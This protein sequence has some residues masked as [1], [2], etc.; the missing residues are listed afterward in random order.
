MKN[1]SSLFNYLITPSQ[2]NKLVYLLNQMLENHLLTEELYLNLIK[3]LLLI[4]HLNKDCFDIYYNILH[5]ISFNIDIIKTLYSIDLSKQVDVIDT[6]IEDIIISTH[7]YIVS[8]YSFP[9]PNDKIIEWINIIHSI[10]KLDTSLNFKIS[11]Y[12]YIIKHSIDI[13][14]IINIINRLVHR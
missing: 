8:N 5:H 13:N 14:P 1:I 9:N 3:S 11:F 2:S 7:N 12:L 6:V 10:N 4:F